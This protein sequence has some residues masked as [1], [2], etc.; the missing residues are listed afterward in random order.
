MMVINI[1]LRSFNLPLG[2]ISVWLLYLI[3]ISFNLSTLRIEINEGEDICMAQ[4]LNSSMSSTSLSL[5]HS[6]T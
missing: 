2:H 6:C 3:W 4:A 5:M 1:V